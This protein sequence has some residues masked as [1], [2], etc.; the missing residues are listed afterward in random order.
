MSTN[1]IDTATIGGVDYVL[2]DSR[3]VWTQSATIPRGR[4]CGDADGDGLITTNDTGKVSAILSGNESEPASGSE[5]FK[6]CDINNDGT[7]NS[8]D[9]FIISQCI[10]GA[11]SIG[12]YQEI[13]GHWTNI[14][15]QPELSSQFYTDIPV[16]GITT[17]N[18]VLVVVDQSYRENIFTKAECGN[19]YVRIYVRRC[20][21]TNVPCVLYVGKGNGTGFV[22]SD[23]HKSV[24]II[25][26]LYAED[27]ASNQQT[28]SI[29]GLLE[30]H[31]V[32]LNIGQGAKKSVWGAW[33]DAKPYVFAQS[34]GSLTI[35]ITGTVPTVDIPVKVTMY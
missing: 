23:A 33:I 31:G 27:W 5:D 26:E 1:F 17:A 12:N 16:S 24:S 20:P 8:D 32:G 18:S 22:L 9:S 14:P 28:L 10:Y 11:T 29:P 7:I 4:M 19:G 13:T 3:A 6:A 25:R 21:A 30:S 15:A 35:K 34:A 2:R